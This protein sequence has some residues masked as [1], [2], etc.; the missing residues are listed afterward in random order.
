MP[1]RAGF[2]LDGTV[3]DMYSALRREAIELF[4]EDVLRAPVKSS[5][6]QEAGKEQTP[7]PKVED[8]QTATLAIQESHLTARQQ[9]QL[10][11]HVKKIENFWTALPELEPGAISRI[12][13]A[14]ADRRWGV[15]FL[16]TRQPE[17]CACRRPVAWRQTRRNYH[18]SPRAVRQRD[19]IRNQPSR[20]R[21][22]KQALGVAT[23]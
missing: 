23:D 20:M 7:Q 16:T 2:D 11:D 14:A 4:G 13:T 12:A 19:D 18:R 17:R 1:L 21:S 5:K 6:P 3:V 9:N 8:D 15:I 22:F 10:W